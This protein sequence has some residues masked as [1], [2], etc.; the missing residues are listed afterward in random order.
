[1]S[2]AARMAEATTLPILDRRAPSG[3]HGPRTIDVDGRTIKLTNLDR[4]LY[5]ETGFTKAD[6]IGYVLATADRALPYVAGRPLTAGRFPSGVDGRGFAQPD[7][8]GRP[9]WMRAM[10]LELA[11][12][13]TKDFTIVDDRAGLVWLAQMGVIELHAF[14]GRPDDLATP[15]Q[16]VFDLDP[17]ATPKGLLDAARAALLVRAALERRGLDARVKTSGSVGIHVLAPVAPP[18]SY[19]ET[20]AIAAEVASEIATAAPEL[21]TTRMTRAERGTRVLVDVRQN[22]QRLTT[23]LPWSLRAAPVPTVSTPLAWREVAAAV[24]KEDAARLV[25]MAADVLKRADSWA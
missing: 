18:I 22:S 25:F 17:P 10:K 5:P 24:E 14:L 11:K 1:M 7:V 8:P 19:P 21:V 15:E 12:G 9:H 13:G 4:V 6:V 20:R 23:V 3:L 2:R 16:I